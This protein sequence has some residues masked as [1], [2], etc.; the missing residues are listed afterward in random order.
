MPTMAAA[1]MPTGVYEGVGA[2]EHGSCADHGGEC[3]APEP[4]WWHAAC[5]D[6]ELETVSGP[7][8]AYRS[9]G[10]SPRCPRRGEFHISY[11]KLEKR[12]RTWLLLTSCGLYSFFFG[13]FYRF[14][15]AFIVT[16]TCLS[17]S[18][19]PSSLDSPLCT[20]AILHI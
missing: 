20:F 11:D 12:A 14:V 13:D 17:Y 2:A 8:L 19:R 15:F 7:G 16:A 1:D 6:C 4:D 9:V 5:A 10:P 3:K 18:H